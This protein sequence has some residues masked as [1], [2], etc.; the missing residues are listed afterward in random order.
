[1]KG[2]SLPRP[3]TRPGRFFLLKDYP[4]H[5]EQTLGDKFKI[6]QS[7]AFIPPHTLIRMI[8]EEEPYAVRAAMFILT[9]PVVSYPNSRRT[10]EALE[11]IDFSVVSELFMT[12]TAALADIVLPA[13]WGMEHEE[14]GYWPGWY[15]S[16][17]AYPKVVDPPGEC[18]PDTKI[19]NELAKRMGFREQFWDTDD[20]AL[21]FMLEPAGITYEDFKETRVLHAKKVNERHV[22]RTP[23]KKVEIYSERLE[24]MGYAP[25]PVWE[26]MIVFPE[27]DEAYPLLLTNGK[28][29]AYMLS[30]YK[31]V[32]AVRSMRPE[33]TSEMHPDTARKLGISQGDWANI[34]TREGKIR[35]KISLNSNLDPR[36]VI[37]SFGWW[38]PE[39]AS[40]HYDWEKS[41]IN[42]IISSGPDHDPVTGAV[43]MRGV[44][45]RV[46][47]EGEG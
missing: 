1:M 17:R 28:E 22:Y 14:L 5:P 2:S 38:F 8:L 47:L 9:N 16:I 13:A 18:W 33:P 30:S 7:S 27:S 10:Y 3:F 37:V 41:N 43:Q 25:M 4:R 31:S 44:P 42:M 20:D 46:S 39:K 36:V 29:E 23:S 35:Q 32:P 45:C 6:A 11:K 21:D 24:K 12:P 15:E 19:I 34:E 26:D 40:S